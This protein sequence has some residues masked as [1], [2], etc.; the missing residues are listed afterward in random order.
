[1]TCPT[2]NR[3]C[4]GSKCMAWVKAK[5]REDGRSRGSCGM[6]PEMGAPIIPDPALSPP[7]GPSPRAAT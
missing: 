2:V 3:E 1:M 4:V 6:V 7:G 5:E